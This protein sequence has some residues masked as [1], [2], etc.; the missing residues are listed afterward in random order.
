MERLSRNSNQPVLPIK[1]VQFG[2]GNFLRAFVDWMINGLNEKTDYNA[3]VAIVQPLANGLTDMLTHQDGLYHHIMQGLEGDQQIDEAI[4]NTSVQKAINPFADTKA[5]FDLAELD[6]L[7]LVFSNTTEAG[8]AFDNSDKPAEGALA[9]TFPGKLTQFLKRRFDHFKGAEDSGL[10]IVPCELIADNGVH[11]KKAILDYVELWQLGEDFK[12]WIENHNYF[13]NTLVDRIVPGY[14]REEIDT[15][16]NRI[17][18]EDKL[19]VKSESFHL[20]VIQA[21]E[22]VQKAFPADKHGFNVK[23]VEDINPFRTQKVR[24]LN[25]AHTSMVPVGLLSG[26]ETVSEAVDDEIVGQFVRKTIFEEIVPLI[27][28]PGE[29]PKEFADQVIMRFRNPFI[30]HELMSISLNSI[31]KYKVR[32]LPT[33]LDFI[34]QKGALPK[35]LLFSLACLIKFYV[36]DDFSKKDDPAVLAFF[37]EEKESAD[38]VTKTLSN[39]SFWGQDLTKISGLE[40]EVTEFFNEISAG[41]VKEIVHEL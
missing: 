6:T 32:V 15:I 23:Y 11:L 21:P 7:E 20:F 5:Y 25:G 12:N 17:G 22:Q 1:V 33:V 26:V 39:E 37:E 8:I 36:S 14:P 35:R 9:N 34:D 29:D 4:L 16:L 19:V 27:S 28:I 38:L 18:V 13:A 31:S 30:R 2:E 10:S 24:I 3:G 41:N 40:A